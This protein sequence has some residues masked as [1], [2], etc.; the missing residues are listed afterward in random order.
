MQ[1]EQK[2]LWEG[3][4]KNAVRDN[5]SKAIA[6]YQANMPEH[7]TVFGVQTEHFDKSEGVPAK[8]INMATY[9]NPAKQKEQETVAEQVQ[10]GALLSADNR[11]NEV[12]VVSNMTSEGDVKKLEEDGFSITDSDSRT[13]ITVTDKI[14]AALAQAGV[15][16]SQYGESLS[17]EQLEELTGNPAVTNQILQAL[18]AYDLPAT[19]ANISDS[20]KALAQAA[21]ING[22]SGSAMAY[23]LNNG[24]EPS[25]HNVYI[26]EHSAQQDTVDVTETEYAELDAQIKQIIEEAGLTADESSVADSKWLIANGI[27]LTGENLSYYMELQTLSLRLE[28]G[29]MDWNHVVDVMAKAVA[30]GKRPG[31]ALMITARR[32]L[33]ETR[34]V[35]TN[36][37]RSAM[38]K[39][40]IEIDTQ[41]LEEIVEDLKEQERQYYHE[42]L[43]GAG[44]AAT[45]ENVDTMVQTMDV[46][47][48]MK[49]QPAYV[50]GQVLPEDTVAS[51]HESGKNLQQELAK[52]G[53]SYEALMTAPRKDMGDS[54]QKAFSNVDD[55]LKDL[56]LETSEGNRRAVRIL[57]Y[58]RT[59]VTTE[60]ITA[61]KAMDEQ[62]QRAFRNMNPAVTLEM[63]KRG[64]NPLDMNMEQLNKAA[65]MI[66]QETGNEEQERFSKFLYKLEQNNEISEEERSSYIG[67][68]R[69]IAQVEKSDGA[70]LGFLMN[71]GA[72]ITMRN[73]LTAVRSSKKGVM[74]YTVSDEFEGVEGSVKGER[75]DDQIAAGFQQNC[76]H[77]IMDTVS[78]QKLAALGEENWQNMTPEQLAK[79]LAQM[80]ETSQEQAM[81]ADYR[82]EQLNMYQQALEMPEDVYAFLDRYDI[83]NSLANIMAANDMLRQP[84][85]MMERLWRK[86]NFSKDAMEKIADLKNKV[87]EDFGEALKNPDE[88]K[89]AQETLAE[90]AEHV[91][92][93][94]IIEDGSEVRTLD[95]RAMRQVTRQLALCAKKADE[96]S[97]MI[98]VKTGESVM[99]VSLKVIRGKKEKGFVDIMFEDERLG[100]VTASFQ[101]K[102]GS[103]SGM[104][105]VDNEDARQ[106]LAG[107]LDVLTRSLQTADGGKEA[108]NLNIACVSGLSFARCEM[109]GINREQKMAENGDL[110][111]DS[112]N[113]V[114]T[115]RLYSIA[116]IFIQSIQKLQSV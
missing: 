96:E 64:E 43:D 29:E 114:Q 90:V 32:Q 47:N 97:Y 116:E 48:E 84:N 86:D 94:M 24:L 5:S 39:Q 20:S 10:S 13:I 6:A 105:A 14:K 93:T 99:G 70:A 78:P 95:M 74:D 66:K 107:H 34:L 72:D 41:Q 44:V 104:I 26:A 37:V 89:K 88:L 36:E 19:A 85:R 49:S 91:M 2:N 53:A 82:Q 35:M 16:I 63:I 71:Q 8:S 21:S 22:I 18:A 76:I 92:D 54:I 87:L 45:D 112:S 31:D 57:A 111:D 106:L 67:I 1:V 42:L 100:K 60:N 61:V 59:A 7:K 23:L 102:E 15:D 58:N 68:Y 25:I 12:A 79:A 52:A 65:E 98:P 62:M 4:T 11:K 50:L 83:T 75:I 17:K 3:V 9:E 81:E 30:S 46:F 103:L 38:L 51:I 28:N 115:S 69:L 73:L 40:G 80:E 33:E 56:N 77:D 101:A 108:V 113:Q 55:I 27:A 109:A 110:A